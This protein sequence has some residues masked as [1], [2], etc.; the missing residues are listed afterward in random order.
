MPPSF[1]SL[2]SALV[3]EFGEFCTV[4][5]S[6]GSFQQKCVLSDPTVGMDAPAGALKLAFCGRQDL[7]V[8]PVVG[9]ELELADG[10]TTYR[11]FDVDVDAGDGIRLALAQ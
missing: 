3:S 11:I 8:L 2:N 5:T 9:D 1:P 4:H 6:A 7:A 10:T